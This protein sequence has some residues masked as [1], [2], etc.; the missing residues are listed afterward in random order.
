MILFFREMIKW[1]N[2][3]PKLHNENYFASFSPSE[4]KLDIF[5]RHVNHSLIYSSATTSCEQFILFEATSARTLAHECELEQGRK[6]N[7]I[8][9]VANEIIKRGTTYFAYFFYLPL[10]KKEVKKGTK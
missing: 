3:K 5:S 2:I 9:F 1:K 6:M 7:V 10:P 4:K 8:W